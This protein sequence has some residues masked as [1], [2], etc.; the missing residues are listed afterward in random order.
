VDGAGSNLSSH[1]I[2]VEKPNASATVRKAFFLAASTGFTGRVIAN[3]DITL[4][5]TGISWDQAI[6]NSIGSNNYLA[7]VTSLVKPIMDAAAPGRTTFTIAEVSTSGIDGEIL[8]VVFDDPTQTADQT[9]ILLFGAQNIAGDTFA[10]TLA[11]PI[12][13][14]AAGA[15]ADMGLGISFGFQGS[16]QFSIVNVNGQ[17]LTTAAGGQDDEQD[18][19]AQNGG[20]LTVGGLDDSNANPPNPLATPTGPRDDDE[21]YSLLPFITSTDTSISVFTQNPSNDD[22]I[23]FAYFVLSTAAIVGE[24]VVLSPL[25]ATNPVGAQHTVTATVVDTNGNPVQGR[26]V[27][28]QVLSG[29][30]AG[31]SGTDTTDANGEATFTYTGSGGAG[32]DQIQA[33]FIDSLSNTKFSN[34]VTKDWVAPACPACETDGSG[35]VQL[36]VLQ[37]VTVDFNP[38]TPTCSGDPDLCAFFSFDK[39]GP[40]PDTWKAIFDVGGKK[41]VVKAGVTITTVPVPFPLNSPTNKSAPGIELRSTCE[42]LIEQGAALVV[43]A[44]SQRAGDILIQIDGNITIDGTVSNAVS[45]ADGRAG[46]VTIASCCGGIATGPASRI[47]TRSQSTSGSDITLLT[48]CDPGGDIVINGL[49]DASYKGLEGGTGSTVS[50]VSFEGSVTID[51]TNILGTD[52]AVT[53]GVTVRATRGPVPGAINIQAKGDVTV[54]GNAILNRTRPNYGAVALKTASR[55]AAG[56]VMAVQSLGGR[57]VA[58]DRAFDN[59]NRSN[60]NARIDLAARG[61]IDMS[62]TSSVNQGASTNAKAVLTTQS[63]TGGQGGTNA[64]RSFSGAI[65]IGANAQSLATAGSGG[66]SGQ[67]LLTSCA[68][69]TNNGTVAPPDLVPGDDSGVCTPAAPTPTFTDC[70]TDF[71]VVFG[72]T[73]D[74]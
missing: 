44:V 35:I 47:E 52:P 3:G 4:N 32:T 65:L 7:D 8:V 28:F 54:V 46:R 42:L 53:S 61:D 70:E 9:V 24:G 60:A 68:G 14:A 73:S 2:Q 41:L 25:S 51:G 12:D 66:T 23:F 31:E 72:G 10:I 39:S 67:N 43:A 22:N 56:G 55:S 59:A 18:A 40:T 45:G 69:V 62:V 74:F 19:F 30:N 26:L 1:T 29:P 71:G 13:P 15:R 11:T 6:S 57:I 58:S 48:C 16:S 17:R 33:S 50:I 34:I 36:A 27:T 20:L 49:V 38:A 21:L 37:N 63:T 5:G 64:L